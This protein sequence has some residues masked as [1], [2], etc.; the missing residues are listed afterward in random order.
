MALLGTSLGYLAPVVLG[1]WL[2]RRPREESPHAEVPA[3]WPL[4]REAI[5]GAQALL[6]FFTLANVDIVVARHVLSAA[7]SGLYAFGLL[8]TK[9]M[10]FLPQFVVIV[11]FP[12]LATVHQRRRAVIRGTTAILAL[13]AVFTLGV[14]VFSG[15]AADL[16]RSEKLE[17]VADHLWLFAVLGTLLSIIQLLVYA[18]L[19]RQGRRSINLVWAALAAC[20]AAGLMTTTPT[21]LLTVMIAVTTALA[22]ALGWLSLRVDAQSSDSKASVGGVVPAAANTDRD[23]ERDE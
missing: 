4:L 22:A 18:T 14:A 6:A 13:G 9:T 8:V 16:L 5:L 15:I 7:E 10:L 12:S 2:L 21:G 20:V 11:M 17:A 19:A 1:W 23:V 3:Q